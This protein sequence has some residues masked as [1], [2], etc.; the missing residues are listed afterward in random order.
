[1]TAPLVA[2]HWH[3]WPPLRVATNNHPSKRRRQ[4]NGETNG[5]IMIK[6]ENKSQ[7]VYIYT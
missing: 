5:R 2:F 4:S 3:S 6:D 7:V 1:V